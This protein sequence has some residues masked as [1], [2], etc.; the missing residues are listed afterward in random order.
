[1]KKND[2]LLT[3][4][5]YAFLTALAVLL[6]GVLLYRFGAVATAIG[7][8]LTAIRSVFIGIAIALILN[9]T[10]SFFE[11][12]YDKLF[13]KKKKKPRLVHALGL[14]TTYLL[15]LLLLAGVIRIL[16]P[17]LIDAVTKLK[18]QS[19]KVLAD[20]Q[21]RIDAFLEKIELPSLAADESQ[22][23]LHINLAEVLNGWA[24]SL[25]G[26]LTGAL[27]GLLSYASNAFSGFKDYFL[28]IVISVYLL[29]FR[30]SVKAGARRVTASVFSEKHAVA[31]SEI[32]S[33]TYRTYLS[34]FTAKF[35]DA[36]I[37][38]C[39]SYIAFTVLE[40]PYAILIGLLFGV[41]NL[42]PFVGPVIGGFIGW[43]IVLIFAPQKALL[44]I[45]VILAIQALDSY[46]IEKYIIGASVIGLSSFWVLVSVT[47]M[48]G[49]FGFTGMLL[50]APT[51]AMGRILV[52]RFMEHVNL[53][54]EEKNAVSAESTEEADSEKTE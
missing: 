15:L 5:V 40:I 24:S 14:I 27:P 31:L 4:A 6:F 22:E 19:E 3:V 38:C 47:I 52:L 8:V 21:V 28:G 23:K 54:K 2:N 16:I 48:G 37:V 11:Q 49:L 18:G 1:M 7:G 51:F 36:T 39:I 20:L 34:F 26:L 12:S 32:G 10:L 50:A 13:C 44:Y 9:P 43:I 17:E 45:L 46:V 53:K 42:I 41:L 30:N 29:A 33:I 35:Y 25:I